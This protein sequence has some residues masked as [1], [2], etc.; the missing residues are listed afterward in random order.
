MSFREEIYFYVGGKGNTFNGGGAGANGATSKNGGGATDVRLVSGAWNNSASLNSRIMV[1]GGGGSVTDESSGAKA[2]VGG[3]ATGG[4]GVPH[5]AVPA[6]YIGHGGGTSSGGAGGTS[7]SNGSF[8]I[9]G[10]GGLYT[11][12]HTG[13][14]GGGGYY[15]GG[16]STWHAGSGG[17]SSFISGYIGCVCINTGT[18]IY[19]GYEF[20]N[21]EMKA[22]DE[23]M[24]THDGSS[25]MIGN[26]GNGYAKIT[27]IGS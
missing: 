12:G 3:K 17:G 9:G 22:G 26:S 5:S 20:S 23:S 7:A 19:T 27:Y 10:N 4:D 16:G 8:G 13:A 11:D 14:G 21:V 2:G 18:P 6:S 25:T 15:G 1:A 24:P